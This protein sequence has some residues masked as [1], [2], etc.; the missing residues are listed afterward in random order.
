MDNGPGVAQSQNLGVQQESSPVFP[1]VDYRQ[2]KSS[3]PN[4]KK[5]LM[6]VLP[7][8][9]VLL[10]SIIGLL[11]FS[12]ANKTSADTLR[13]FSSAT[14]EISSE[15]NNLNTGISRITDDV[16]LKIEDS[17]ESF[18]QSIKKFEDTT[19]KL[20][21]DRKELK[22][23]A[24]NYALALKEYRSNEVEIAVDASKMS[25][26]LKKWSDIKST[27]LTLGNFD[28]D[29]E[30]LDRTSGEY[31][32]VEESLKNLELKTEKGKELRDTYVEMLGQMQVF[33]ANLKTA[34]AN[35]D[36]EAFSMAQSKM[37]DDPEIATTK[38]RR[39]SLEGE[40]EDLTGYNNDGIKKV[41]EARDALNSEIKSNNSK[42]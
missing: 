18:D 5:I 26:A 31:S 27:P 25:P 24:E 34:I 32:S 33:F 40:L 36:N 13:D 29:V 41:D 14:S 20:K 38:K 11:L 10:I 19:F 7:I 4:T 1:G 21:S 12:K 39:K 37:A 3:G 23:A 28:G 30:M 8:V 35:Q 2:P 9:G 16:E 17:V 6:I 42:S 15:S 22:L